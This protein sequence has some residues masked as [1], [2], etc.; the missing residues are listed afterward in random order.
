MAGRKPRGVQL[1]A[2]DIPRLEALVRRGKTEQRVAR[3]ARIL[4]E[5]HR[6]KRVQEVC[7]QVG[8]HRTTVWRVCRRYEARGIEAV[9]DAPRSG[10]PRRISPLERARWENLACTRPQEHGLEW[11]HGSVWTRPKV[12]A[13][14]SIGPSLGRVLRE[15]TLQPHPDDA[16]GRYGYRAGGPGVGML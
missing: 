4:L 9:Y 6:G 5:I 12:A 2:E 10:R 16:V 7:R 8:E 11:T 15:A 13:R 1:R 14:E 3:R